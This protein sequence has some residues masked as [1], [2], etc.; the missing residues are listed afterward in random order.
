M[1]A[2]SKSP[3][4]GP[5]AARAATIVYLT[6]LAMLAFAANSLLTRAAFQASSIDAASFTAIRIASGAFALCL[7]VL[8]QGATLPLSRKRGWPAFLLFAYVAAF[9]F[10]YRDISV[11]AGALILFAAAQLTMISYGVLRGERASILGM[12]MAIGG[13][14]AFLAPGASAPPLGPTALMAVAGLAWGAFSLTGKSGDAPVAGTASS[15]LLALPMS[16]LLLLAYRSHVQ[17]DLAGAL[18]AALSGALA[19]GVGYAIWYWVRVRMTAISA[20][21]VQLSVPVISAILGMV[22]LDERIT[23]GRAI[24]ALV[25]LAG[26]AVVTLT[27]RRKQA[28]RQADARG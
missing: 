3:D 22:F 15:F 23:P 4:R 21:A 26:V 20:G 14:A 5:P 12:S 11:G 6:G 27:A 16:L 18:Y 25:V 28:A 1:T 10:A 2:D 17:I 9:S 24:A 8:A 7:I 13:I 19:S